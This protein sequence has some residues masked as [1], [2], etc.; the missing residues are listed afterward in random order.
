VSCIFGAK[1]TTRNTIDCAVPPRPMFRASWTSAVT[2]RRYRAGRQAPV[3]DKPARSLT[4]ALILAI[5][6]AGRGTM[7]LYRPAAGG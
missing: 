4:L 6:I 2:C 7:L 3:G 5:A 1:F